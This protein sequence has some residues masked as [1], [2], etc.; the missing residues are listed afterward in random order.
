MLPVRRI[1]RRP[2]V[3]IPGGWPA[4]VPAVHALLE[5]GLEL[6]PSTVL[7]GENGSGKSTIVE[8]IAAL[9][10]VPSGGG[11][12]Q[13]MFQPVEASSPLPGLLRL[14]RSPASSK[15]AYFLRAETMHGLY[16]YLADLPNAVDTDLHERSHGEGFL[17][18]LQRKSDAHG[19]YLLDEPE[20]ALS[21][22]GCLALVGHLHAI[23]ARGAQVIVATHSP[24]VAS[25]PDATILELGDWGIR[26]TDWPDTELVTHH[27]L[28]LDAPAAFL[29]H[30]VD[31]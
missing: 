11:S 29:R 17:T 21:F 3:S 22:T 13:G 8:A 6:G 2:D 7:L 9:L 15:W 20:S 23:A 31:D 14:E 5:E 4:T 10:G 16:S 24:V 18:I 28:F 27:R 26:T 25:L 1:A 12:N 19:V 30:V